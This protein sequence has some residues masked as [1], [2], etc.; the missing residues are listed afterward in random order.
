[1]SVVTVQ[2]GLRI[3]CA[4][5]PESKCLKFIQPLKYFDG[6]SH[7]IKGELLLPLALRVVKSLV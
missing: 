3:Y 2:A 4:D 1:M 7:V 5:L 6:Q